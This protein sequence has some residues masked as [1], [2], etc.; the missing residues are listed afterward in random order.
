MINVI[1]VESTPRN[2]VAAG[3]LRNVLGPSDEG[4]RVLIAIQEVS[5][6]ALKTQ[7]SS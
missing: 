4:T 1:D 7:P 2:A 3:H 6:R 5:R